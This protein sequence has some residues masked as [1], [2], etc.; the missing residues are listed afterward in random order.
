[1]NRLALLAIS[2]ALLTFSAVPARAQSRS[3]TVTAQQPAGILLALMNAG[4]D[5]ALQTDPVGDPMI[6]VEGD[7]YPM[8]VLFYE[9]DEQ[10][11]D[12]CSSLQ[13]VTGLDRDKPWSTSETD[14]LMSELRFIAV[15]LDEEGDPIFTWDLFTGDGIPTAAF[16]DTVGRFENSVRSAAEKVFA[17]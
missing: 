12:R 17:D 11:N 16:L 7:G 6:K 4:Y 2:A 9:C 3:D 5:A 1:M 14:K 13:L 10:T 15:H 8:T